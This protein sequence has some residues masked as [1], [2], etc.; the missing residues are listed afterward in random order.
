MAEDKV[1]EL[2]AKLNALSQGK[3]EEVTEV[4]PQSNEV[5]P[6]KVPEIEPVKISTPSPEPVKEQPS[7]PDLGQIQEMLKQLL[8]QVPQET[9]VSEP[10][11]EEE[12]EVVEEPT[13]EENQERMEQL[14]REIIRMRDDGA[15]RVEMIYQLINI[16][17]TLE[18][19]AKGLEQE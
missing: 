6:E 17:N 7:T 1:A 16:N 15:Y 11:V 3:K 12:P 14:T 19:I 8:A 4:T 18:R 9:K 10:E 5:K 13:E 2:R